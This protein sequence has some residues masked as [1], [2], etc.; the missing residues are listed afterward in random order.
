MSGVLPLYNYT[1]KKGRFGKLRR[2][3]LKKVFEERKKAQ[4]FGRG[5]RRL[6][7]C[8][9]KYF[10][11][12]RQ[13]RGVPALCD[14]RASCSYFLLNIERKRGLT[15]CSKLAHRRASFADLSATDRSREGDGLFAL[16]SGVPPTATFGIAVLTKF[17]KKS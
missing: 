10:C 13:D 2:K 15:P 6:S 12:E 1:D 8:A 14:L 3:K 17:G 7:N 9:S 5:K 4:D 16:Y 11:D